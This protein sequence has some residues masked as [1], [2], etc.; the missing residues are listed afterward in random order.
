[1]DACT[2][3]RSEGTACAACTDALR[4]WTPEERCP[5][6]WARPNSTCGPY[7]AAQAFS[8]FAR[9]V[10]CTHSRHRHVQALAWALPV[11]R[12]TLEDHS[13]WRLPPAVNQ[14]CAHSAR[15]HVS[16]GLGR[17]G[18][19]L[20]MSLLSQLRV[21]SSSTSDEAWVLSHSDSGSHSFSHSRP[22]RSGRRR[23]AGEV[24]GGGRSKREG[25][26]C[27]SF[28]ERRR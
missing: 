22:L 2:P 15:S 11:A 24:A 13:G 14:S 27:L 9:G 5:K 10:A 25:V 20:L 21:D 18:P 12:G 1:M 28:S 19:T 6:V 8:P 16:W 3:A 26:P 17:R 4:G 23:R 7:G